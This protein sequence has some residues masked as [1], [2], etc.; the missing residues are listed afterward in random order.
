MDILMFVMGLALGIGLA[1]VLMGRRVADAARLAR[2]EG[3]L[4][5]ATL[6]ER[7]EAER[8]QGAEKLAVLEEA[9]GELS[10]QFKVLASEILEE[11]A[12]RFTEQNQENLGRLLDPLRVKLAEFQGKVEDVYV[13]EGQERSAL[14]EQVRALMSLNK[15]LSDDAHNL[16][17]AL[18]GSAKT[19]GNWGEMI[20]ERILESSGLR[21]GHEYRV[22]ESH[23]R[24]DGSRAQPDVII[25]LPEERHLVVDAK[26]SLTAYEAYAS[27]DDDARRESAARNHVDSVRAHIRELSPKNYQNLP[28]VT[29]LD[30]VIMFIP[31]EP[32]FMLAISREPGLWQ[33]AW[34]RNVLLVSPSTLL[35]VV[36]T[37]AHLWRQ[38]QQSRNAQ[39]IARR[40]AELYDKLAGFVADLTSLGVRLKQAQED[41][42]K[43]L[44]KFATGKGNVIRQAE[45]LKELG[46]KPARNLPQKTVEASEEN[47]ESKAD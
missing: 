1:V 14:A 19:Q 17:T 26:V 34:A 27:A 36:R 31:V 24:E 2:S 21:R 4:E 42:D 44:N 13:R 47:P 29:S 22:Q 8:K 41:Y 35:F 25:Q 32:A 9:R 39:E 45:M 23:A 28:G 33:E 43:A 38:E 16:T 5:A 7:L 15:Q 30:F 11:K 20:L 10:N 12:R 6:R 46:I 3:Q 40:G 18:K 37:V